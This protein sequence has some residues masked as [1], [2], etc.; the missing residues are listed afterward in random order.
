[1]IRV[2]LCKQEGCALIRLLSRIFISDYKNTDNPKVRRAYGVLC[3]VVGIA[4][5]VLLFAIKYLAGAIT[6][7]IAV[8]ADAYNNLSD[9]G[10]SL[11]TLIGFR[12]SGKKSDPEH[13]FGH[14]RVEYIAGLIVAMLII[15]MGLDLAGD[16]IQSIRSPAPVD[17][18]ALSMG[19]LAVSVLIKLYMAVYNHSVG[20]KINSVAMKATAADS[21][22]DA[23]ATS[24]VLVSA[25][26]CRFTGWNIDGY[27][28]ALVSVLILRAGWSAAM[29]TISPLL[30]N[31]PAPEFVKNVENIVNSYEG[32]VGI[33]DLVVHDYGAGRT[34]ISLHAE[35]P[36]DGDMM[37]LH[38]MIDTIE[39]RL[40]DD[41]GC[42]AVIHM[43]P[44]VTDDSAVS[45]L[46]ELVQ[47]RICQ[48][49]NCSATVHDFRMVPGHTH[50]NII[51]D[52]VIPLTV[53]R[54]DSALKSEICRIVKDLNETYFAV[55]TIDRPYL[56]M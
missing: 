4:L 47:E 5:N 55:V 51:F 40:S 33:H 56:E 44:V 15:H 1:M 50:T 53:P 43:D 41:L 54:S 24:A 49:L 31:P 35:V 3:G 17:F 45:E 36:A 16:S 8:M 32:V 29:D 48:E 21:I 6:G 7:S 42:H 14:G 46:R 39:R 25:L 19:I 52:A 30:G 22:S 2:K 9:A 23:V 37:V 27:T 20:R 18:S 38:D 13:P 28:G 34:M 10:S 26:I 12:I 11:V